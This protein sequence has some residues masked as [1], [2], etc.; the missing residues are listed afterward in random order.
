MSRIKDTLTLKLD[1]VIT[2]HFLKAMGKN[3]DHG[4]PD[5]V[6]SHVRDLF[7]D[8]G[9]QVDAVSASQSEVQMI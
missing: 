7:Q 5:Q 2:T 6:S 9:G 1:E 3:T 4:F 8:L